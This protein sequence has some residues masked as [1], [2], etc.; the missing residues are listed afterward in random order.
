VKKYRV[1]K[2]YAGRGLKEQKMTTYATQEEAAAAAQARSAELDEIWE[3]VEFDGHN[4]ADVWDE[5]ES[6]EGWDGVSKRC[7]C[8]NRRVDWVFSE[9]PKGVWSFYAE[10]Y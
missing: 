3:T 9:Y 6:C 5:G 8:G 2:K 10:A 4:C 7:Q 1:P